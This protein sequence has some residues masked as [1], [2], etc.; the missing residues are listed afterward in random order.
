MSILGQLERDLLAAAR[1]RQMS[2]T[3]EPRVFG[4]EA[5]R[6]VLGV[7]LNRLRV[8]ALAFAALLASGT[9]ALAASDLILTGSPVS[10][11]DQQS[12]NVGNGV[13]A[14]GASELLPLRV[15]DPEGGLPWGMRLVHTT[16]GKLCMQVGRVKDGEL[17]E[18]GV[19]GAFNNDGRF[20]PL[21]ASALPSLAPDGQ[22]PAG[23]ANTSCNLIG[24]AIV[25]QHIGLDRSAA[26]LSSGAQVAI[27][28]R[29]DLYFGVL[30]SDA[31]SVSYGA[32]E[33]QHT[34]PVVPESGAYLVVQPT[35]SGEQIET[36]AAAIGT[37][38]NSVPSA[39]LTA[40]AYRIDGKLCERGPV[41]PPWASNPG[42]DTCP[43]VPTPS[44]PAQQPELRVPLHVEVQTQ[45]GLIAGVDVSFTAPYAIAD[46]S[47]EY[48][49]RV[50]DCQTADSQ[51]AVSQSLERNVA[52]G[53]T[54][55]LHL[56]D[57]FVER[58]GGLDAKP[59]ERQTVTVEALYQHADGGGSV[60]VGSATISEPPG[61]QPAPA[62]MSAL[63]ARRARRSAGATRR[64]P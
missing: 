52:K 8:P 62:Q 31:V 29:R 63:S 33:G 28:Y 11:S 27:R 14:A 38:G 36:G 26:E 34:V 1:Q 16:R 19:D 37:Y 21:P 17:G 15:S 13:P 44:A 25:A 12:S 64:T 43:Q 18:L 5:R 41:Q 7:S 53:E 57:P 24:E 45:G 35:A 47:Y 30:G 39:P 6:R 50:L 10:P 59:A 3:S 56:G 58:C 42:I 54:V 49:I 32:G 60:V 9:I 61:T 22:Q 4:G 20:H 51:G 2:A 23:D 55:R 48:A 40:I 46:A